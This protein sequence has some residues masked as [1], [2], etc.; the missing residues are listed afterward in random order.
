MISTGA[1][2]AGPLGPVHGAHLLTQAT[3]D[4]LTVGSCGAVS[5]AA[6]FAVFTSCALPPVEWEPS[7]PP[8]VSPHA[9]DAGT[10]AKRT[11]RRRMR[12]LR[13]VA[14]QKTG[15]DG[16]MAL[17]GHV[18]GALDL[19]GIRKGTIVAGYWPIVTEIDVRPLLA[20]LEHIGARAALPV[21]SAPDAPLL[22]RHWSLSDDLEDGPRGTRQPGAAVSTVIPDVVL[23]P[24]LAVDP[25]GCRLGQGGGHYDRTL[26]AL[27]DIRPIVAVGVGYAVQIVD[28]VPEEACDQRMDWILTDAGLVRAGA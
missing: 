2:P 24:L 21:L 19:L 7:M 6:R 14:D 1:V 17:V 22:F 26:A 27:R 5:P 16:A 9:D 25:R 23:V 3:E 20:R 4:H 13:L 15:P 8:L 28:Q 12:A 10:D 11:L 18:T